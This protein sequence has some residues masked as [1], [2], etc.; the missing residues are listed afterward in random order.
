MKPNKYIHTIQSNLG[1]LFFGFLGGRWSHGIIV[2][3]WCT[4]T[5]L[6]VGWD[7][8]IVSQN[9]DT[10]IPKLVIMG[11]PFVLQQAIIPFFGTNPK[12]DKMPSYFLLVPSH[13][14][15]LLGMM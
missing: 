15:G 3:G 5:Q 9:F 6:T 11:D 1:C 7:R 12:G 4:Q 14:T 2:P 8:A 13:L 10:D